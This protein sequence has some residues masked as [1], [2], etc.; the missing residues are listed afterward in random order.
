[1]HG[2]VPGLVKLASIRN[3]PT[4]Q[5][6]GMDMCIDMCTDTCIGHV[7]WHYYSQKTIITLINYYNY[8]RNFRATQSY[9]V[10]RAQINERKK[11]A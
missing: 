8:C 5:T 4:N 2:S 9:Q 1:M 3:E 6:C 11:G 7:Y 10:T